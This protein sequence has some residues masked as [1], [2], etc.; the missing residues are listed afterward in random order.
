MD[1]SKMKQVQVDATLAA[2][3]MRQ[4]TKEYE[5]LYDLYIIRP[6]PIEGKQ[7]FKSRAMSLAVKNI[8]SRIKWYLD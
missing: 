3:T 5:L 2:K 6:K 7:S 4:F 1:N 8:G